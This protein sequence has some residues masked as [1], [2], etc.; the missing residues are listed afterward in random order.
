MGLA[1]LIT[2]LLVGWIAWSMYRK[3]L[4]ATRRSSRKEQLQGKNF[5]QCRF[6]KVHLPEQDAI[7]DGDAWYCCKAHQQAWLEKS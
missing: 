2:F 5:V 3:Y 7:A 1:R 4:A 6:C